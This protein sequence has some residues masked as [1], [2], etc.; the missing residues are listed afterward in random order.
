MYSQKYCLIENEYISVFFSTYI[1]PKVLPNWKRIH[2]WIFFTYIFPKVLPNW[3][4]IY[5][6]SFFSPIYSQKY[7]LI[8]NE[9]ISVFFFST[10]IFPKVLPNW[11]RIYKWTFF[12]LIYSQM[13]C[14]VDRCL[15]VLV[16]SQIQGLTG[17]PNGCLKPVWNQFET[18]WKP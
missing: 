17:T 7:C 12:P 9:Y 8:E 16:I 5:K 1:F 10:Y 18:T 6:W 15:N 3:K 4:R 13:N 11:K 2:K 14:P